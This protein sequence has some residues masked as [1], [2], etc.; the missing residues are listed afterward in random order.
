MMAL[1][2][3]VRAKS[4]SPGLLLKLVVCF[5][6]CGVKFQRYRTYGQLPIHSKEENLKRLNLFSKARLGSRG[7]KCFVRFEFSELITLESQV[8]FSPFCQISF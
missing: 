7:S 3:T 8:E 1:V 6:L 5:T 2:E 4:I